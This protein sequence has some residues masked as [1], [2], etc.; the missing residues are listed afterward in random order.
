MKTY[1]DV[2]EENGLTVEAGEILIELAIEAN[3]QGKVDDVFDVGNYS[4]RTGEWDYQ[5][6]VLPAIR[7]ANMAAEGDVQAIIALREAWG[8]PVFC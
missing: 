2:A 3:Y 1:R 8:L 5:D 4:L 7:A 6:E